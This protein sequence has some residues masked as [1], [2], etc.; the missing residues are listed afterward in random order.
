MTSAP[1]DP[2]ADLKRIA[3]LL[4]AA[5]EPSF[6]VQAFRRAAT[7]LE[8]IGSDEL[9]R[10]IEAGTLR[11]LSGIGE[12]TE[13]TIIE[14]VRGEEPVYLRRLE[15]T[16]GRPMAEGAAQVRA[17][18]RGDCHVHSEWSDGGSPIREMAE[19]ARDLGHEYMVLTDHSP[20]LTVA[21]GLTPERLRAQLDEVAAVN[22]DLA[23]FR[24]LTGIEVDINED[25]SLDQ[26]PE[27]LSRLDLVVGSVHSVL[28]M[29]AP[30][31]TRRR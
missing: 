23:P 9:G 16:G 6:R 29:A 4:E 2:V 15:S 12:V 18:L 17:A 3:F 5:L 19:V 28:R 26:E 22:V 21:N 7:T 24:V 20:R 31:M 30:L 11:E 27:L 14:A 13:R 10:R 25:G 8:T 1:R